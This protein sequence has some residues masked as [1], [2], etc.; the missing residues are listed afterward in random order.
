MP[1]RFTRSLCHPSVELE[2][3]NEESLARQPS[4][5]QDWQG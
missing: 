5:T 3:E 1:E 2:I 4:L